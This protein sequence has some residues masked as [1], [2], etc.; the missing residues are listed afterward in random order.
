VQEQQGGGFFGVLRHALAQRSAHLFAPLLETFAYEG[1]GSAARRSGFGPTDKMQQVRLDIRPRVE[2]PGRYPV[3]RRNF[4]GSCRKTEIAPNDFAS[5]VAPRNAAPPPTAASDTMQ[6]GN[7]PLRISSSH[8]V[9][10][11]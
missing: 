10:I 5:P 1:A 4:V 9:A 11:A 6:S 3:S 8:G 2:A 7:G